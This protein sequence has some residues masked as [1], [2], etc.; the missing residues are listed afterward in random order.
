[1][2]NSS[3]PTYSFNFLPNEPTSQP[4]F[5]AATG[6]GN[7]QMTLNFSGGNGSSY[8]VVMRQGS[9]VSASPTDATS[10]SAVS[11]SV[12]FTT[13]TE[14]SAGQ[15]IVYNGATSGTSVR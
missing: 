9:A 2:T 15:R 10:Y 4:S 13:A 12:D 6:V 8:M 5:T 11:G 14:L 1:M 3:W 7:N